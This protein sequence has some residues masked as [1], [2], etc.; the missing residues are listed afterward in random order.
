VKRLRWVTFEDTSIPPPVDLVHRQLLVEELRSALGALDE[1]R[2]LVLEMHYGLDGHRKHT[3]GE[4]GECL[5]VTRER[6]RQLE[7][8]ALYALRT[9]GNWQKLRSFGLN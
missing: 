1:R 9:P 6:V 4:I 8:R 3:L 5:G 2:R 7:A